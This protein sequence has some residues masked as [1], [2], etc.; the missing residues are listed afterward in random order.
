MPSGYLWERERRQTVASTLG[1]TE[2]QAWVVRLGELLRYLPGI[3]INDG[4][5]LADQS[6]IVKHYLAAFWWNEL[7][8]GLCC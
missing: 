6:H 1:W 4:Q 5:I 3:V 7:I 8:D 2:E